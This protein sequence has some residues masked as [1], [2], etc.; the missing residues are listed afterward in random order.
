[1][2]FLGAWQIGRKEMDNGRMLGLTHVKR[3]L[4]VCLLLTINPAPN[5]HG[6]GLGGCSPC[7]LVVAGVAWADTLVA[8]SDFV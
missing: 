5:Q 7:F 3:F 8:I 4:G 6:N 2:T 1:M